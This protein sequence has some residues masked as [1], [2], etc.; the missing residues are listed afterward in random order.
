M[1]QNAF[2]QS[3]CQPSGVISSHVTLQ[4]VIYAHLTFHP[5]RISLAKCDAF[6]GAP[7]LPEHICSVGYLLLP[8]EVQNRRI[9]HTIKGKWVYKLPEGKLA[10]LIATHLTVSQM[11]Y[12]LLTGNQQLH[13]PPLSLHWSF[14]VRLRSSCQSMA[15]L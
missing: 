6:R 3:P 10:F 12:A 9:F 4:Y 8:L 5:A 14:I 13:M 2:K 15:A 7:R 1:G 11:F